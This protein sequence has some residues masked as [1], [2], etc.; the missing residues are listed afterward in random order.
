MAKLE[1]H[2][3][4]KRLIRLATLRLKGRLGHLADLHEFII[5][6][7]KEGNL[8]TDAALGEI[9]EQIRETTR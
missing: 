7:E 8:L 5:E 2:Q 3:H 6:V 4:A 9:L 1:D